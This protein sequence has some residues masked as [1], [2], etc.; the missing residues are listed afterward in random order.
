LLKEPLGTSSTLFNTVFDSTKYLDIAIVTPNLLHYFVIALRVIIQLTKIIYFAV[1]PNPFYNYTPSSLISSEEILRL[2]DG[3]ETYQNNP[4]W[5]LL[6]RGVDVIIVNDNSADTKD[7][8]PNGSELYNTYIQS[9]NAGLTRMPVIPSVDNFPNG[10]TFFGCNDMTTVT[11]VYLPNHQ[12]T[13]PSNRG[14][15][16][17]SYERHQTQDMIANG[18]EI[19]SKG[20]DPRW[21]LCLACGFMKKEGGTLPT[22]C[23]ACFQQ[24]CYN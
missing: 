1:Y 14:T 20:G 21:P 22:G 15:S 2:V 12:Y 3:G 19:A 24:Y 5:P 4:I 18:V 6:H 7:D 16:K 9:V 10:P 23:S 17:L 13:Y 8:W 11:I